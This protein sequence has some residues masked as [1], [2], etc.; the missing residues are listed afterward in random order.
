MR[1]FSPKVSR[2]EEDCQALLDAAFLYTARAPRRLAADVLLSAPLTLAIR[3]SGFIEASTSPR[4]V[5]LLN[6]MLA[7]LPA[8]IHVIAMMSAGKK[9]ITNGSHDAALI[10]IRARSSRG[11]AAI[12]TT[13]SRKRR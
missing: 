2:V 8:H 6:A 11:F 3:A 9:E 4:R 1:A 7:P 10:S 12:I 13:S 5:S